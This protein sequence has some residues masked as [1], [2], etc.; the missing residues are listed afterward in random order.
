MVYCVDYRHPI[1]LAK[2]AAM[3]QFFSGGRI[4]FGIGAGWSKEDYSQSNIPMD[5]PLKR[6]SR[7]EESV[8]IIKSLWSNEKTSYEGE[9]FVIKDAANAQDLDGLP[10]PALLI[11]G[12]G[13]HVLSMAGRH[14]DIVSLIPSIPEGVLTA[15]VM[16]RGM[17]EDY[18]MKVKWV[19]ESARAST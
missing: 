6:I 9:H 19:R 14:A 1:V 2:A 11:G 15:E 5:K 16:K 12:G 18:R 17:L 4:E 8:K 7:L 13:R 10:P 3:A